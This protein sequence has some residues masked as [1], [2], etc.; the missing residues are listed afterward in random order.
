M[1]VLNFKI[2]GPVVPEKSWTVKK[3]LHTD[4][5]CY[6]KYK[7]YNIPL[8]YFVYQEYNKQICAMHWLFIRA[9]MFKANDDVS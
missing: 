6:G 3:S 1:F 4:T 7:N 2:L 9:Q 5:H 8:I